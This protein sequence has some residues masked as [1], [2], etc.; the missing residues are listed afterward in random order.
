MIKEYCLFENL[1]KIQKP[2]KSASKLYSSS[3]SSS[4]SLL[5]SAAALGV[6]A[7]G[8]VY[9]VVAELRLLGVIY[10]TGFQGTGRGCLSAAYI[11]SPSLGFVV[12]SIR[13]R[14]SVDGCG[15]HLG[16][17]T[18]SICFVLVSSP[19]AGLKNLIWPGLTL[20]CGPWSLKSSKNWPSGLWTSSRLNNDTFRCLSSVNLNSC[21]R[22][23][24][25]S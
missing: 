1:V 20:C 8:V 25:K 18:I 10:T 11:F 3:S 6:G 9:G 24:V 2:T 19:V 7:L 16:A 12:T 21:Y 22:T 15:F 14:R 13:F 4:G 23:I 17:W 5:S